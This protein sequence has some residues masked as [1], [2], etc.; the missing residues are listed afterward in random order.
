MNL[1]LLNF[2]EIVERWPL[3]RAL[4]E[5]GPDECW[6]VMDELYEADLPH[7]FADPQNGDGRRKMV[8]SARKHMKLVPALEDRDIEEMAARYGTY[9][10]RLQKEVV[11][12]L[13]WMRDHTTLFN[14]V[15][16]VQGQDILDAALKIGNGVL[17][18]PVHLGPSYVVGPM[19]AH[20][21]PS[22]VVF[23]RIN[24]YGCKGKTFPNLDAEAV[25]LSSSSNI[26][27]VGIEALKTKRTFVIFPELDPRGVG[28]HHVRVPFLGTTVMVPSGP[29][30]MSRIAKAPILPI[31]F[32][33]N[34]NGTFVLKYHDLIEPSVNRKEDSAVVHT[35]WESL[36][37]IILEGP[38]E[39][40]EIWLE[41]DK[42]V[43]SLP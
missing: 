12:V 40:W 13:L 39:D 42:M 19:L 30:I 36:N 31:S 37:Q 1:P 18:V 34:G 43:P 20:E 17:A 28:Q 15:V 8:A 26:A 41:F 29:V 3:F 33:S 22:T 2:L 4:R 5:L 11:F 24:F 16:E 38:T 23:N 9:G 35:L 6:R 10:P 32:L 27:R 7:Y 14:E 25:G 21:N